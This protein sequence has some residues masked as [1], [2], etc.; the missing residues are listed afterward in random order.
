[1]Q[2]EHQGLIALADWPAEPEAPAAV[3]P[4]PFETALG[5]LCRGLG[6]S[7]TRAFARWILESSEHH[8]VD[9]FLLAAVIYDQSGCK[10]RFRAKHGLGLAAL[11]WRMHRRSVSAKGYRYF[12]WDLRLGEWTEKLLRT[13]RYRFRPGH[14]RNPR[15]AIELAAALLRVYREQCPDID[16]PFGSVPHRHHVSHFVWG[17]VV[18]DP[19]HEDNILA[20][21]RRLLDYYRGSAPAPCG[22]YKNVALFSPV[23][24]TPRKVLSGWDDMR[25]RGGRR[26]HRGIDLFTPRGSPIYAST[27]GEVIFAG[28][29]VRRRWGGR[30]VP[31]PFARARRIGRARLA[32]SGYFVMI[33]HPEGLISAYMHLSGYTVQKG[34]QVKGGQLIGYSGDTGI[35]R[36]K[37]HLHFEL[38]EPP[39]EHFDPLPHFG[40]CFIPPEA[41][42]VGRWRKAYY[43]R[44][45][46]ARAARRARWL[47]RRARLQALRAERRARRL[48]R[49][50]AMRR[51][52][53]APAPT[54]AAIP[55]QE[56]AGRP[57]HGG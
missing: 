13:R 22:S 48:A 45:E 9:P 49:R 46:L 35:R 10:A 27:D 3:E 11:D 25:F 43:E 38:R 42:Y 20:A 39:R 53:K 8:E 16:A 19:A 52:Q 41:T 2:P 5:T 12:V 34:D 37:P 50:A 21:R 30:S 36:S 44:V 56:E 17:D 24:G 31:M 51:R 40:R 47:E 33:Q 1:M 18:P 23:D 14:M 28:A 26:R 32:L 29:S 6:R 7:A 55:A 15:G 54:T 4:R 57:D